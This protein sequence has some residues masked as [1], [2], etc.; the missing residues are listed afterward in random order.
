MSS[1][2]P[3]Q[4]LPT[5]RCDDKPALLESIEEHITYSIMPQS[6]IAASLAGNTMTQLIAARAAEFR[7]CSEND[8]IK[9][10]MYSTAVESY[11]A[12]DPEAFSQVATCLAFCGNT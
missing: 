8:T 11:G 7:K 10:E 9:L 6:D 4:P 1:P 2:D 12:C 5:S 3:M